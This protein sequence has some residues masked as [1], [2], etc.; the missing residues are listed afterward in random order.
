M[1][2][3]STGLGDEGRHPGKLKPLTVTV[4]AAAAISGISTSKLWQM[5]KNGTLPVTRLGRR[6]LIHFAAL[7]ALMLSGGK[8]PRQTPNRW[9]K[10]A[11]RGSEAPR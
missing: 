8:P 6:T 11:S 2:I 5:I 7:E 4:G 9:V 1:S 10:A 3:A